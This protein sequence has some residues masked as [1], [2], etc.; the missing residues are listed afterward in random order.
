MVYFALAGHGATGL[1]HLLTRGCPPVLVVTD[2][3]VTAG[4]P[5]VAALNRR[6]DQ[7]L[8]AYPDLLTV[9][10]EHRVPVYL[11]RPDRP[12]T[13]L[14]AAIAALQPEVALINTYFRI[15]SPAV[16]TLPPCGTYNLHPSLLPAYRG[17][18]PL[19]WAIR[20]GEPET[21][22]SLQRID[23]GID[24][25]PVFAQ[26]RIPIGSSDTFA[27]VY[28]RLTPLVAPL[29]DEFLLRFRGPGT[30]LPA[31]T[32]PS[33]QGLPDTAEC[34]LNDQDL[35]LRE[36]VNLIRAGNPTMPAFV[37]GS[38]YRCLVWQAHPVPAVASEQPLVVIDDRVFLCLRD[39]TLAI[40]EFDFL[41]LPD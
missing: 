27:D 22:M 5:A 6:R 40:T 7:L 9:C 17:P 13:E 14:A 29:L 2:G 21:G 11:D 41:H 16:F 34:C 37:A 31:T 15:L 25:G 4:D 10:H 20:N 26:H 12:Q 39:G 30:P 8:A 38:G 18:Q 28:H 23:A 32:L 33:A 35:T 36:A 3:R 24:T 19:Y 1:Q